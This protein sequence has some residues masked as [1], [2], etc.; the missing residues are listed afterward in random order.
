MIFYGTRETSDETNATT[1]GL[2]MP[3]PT[4][5]LQV[6]EDEYVKESQGQVCLTKREKSRRLSGTTS[7]SD[8]KVQVDGKEHEKERKEPKHNAKAPSRR[9]SGMNSKS[10]VR[11]E[12]DEN[13]TEQQEEERDSNQ[14]ETRILSGRKSNSCPGLQH[15]EDESARERQET[16]RVA[17]KVS[18]KIKRYAKNFDS[19]T[20]LDNSRIVPELRWS[21]LTFGDFLGKGSF[22]LV[23]EVRIKEKALGKLRDIKTRL[24]NS[25]SDINNELGG[26]SLSNNESKY[27]RFSTP[28]EGENSDAS[29]EIGD[30]FNQLDIDNA[31]YELYDA[32]EYDGRVPTIGTKYALKR[33]DLDHLKKEKHGFTDGA[34]DL[35][36]EAKLLRCI[37][38]E[39]IF[40]LHAVTEGSYSKAFRNEGY[41]LL[42]DRLY[43]TLE[44]KLHEWSNED[45]IVDQLTTPR[46]V[47]KR[48]AMDERLRSI[49]MPIV[50]AMKYLHKRK[51]V[52]RD[53]KPS[54]VGFT[55]TG[56]LKMFDFGLAKEIT[57]ENERHMTGRTGS[58]RY[59][60]PE[61]ALSADYNLSADVYSFAILLWEVC[62]L[63]RAFIGMTQEAHMDLIV[64]GNGRPM[65]DIFLF[66][67][68]ANLLRNSWHVNSTKR[69]SFIEINHLLV[70][71]FIEVSSYKEGASSQKIMGLKE[72]WLPIDNPLSR[73]VPT[74]PYF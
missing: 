21:D 57:K 35:V 30:V 66:G 11:L 2:P 19:S 39:D 14:K 20:S 50:N 59:M 3:Y 74:L 24:N 32:Q 15:D 70:S 9:I 34:I 53:L 12:V 63:Q 37:D 26:I 33:L 68:M 54:N 27:S 49:I 43:G 44:E 16:K 1:R 40:K 36:L 47:L 73:S 71:R 69:P 67:E 10:Y 72:K 18:S 4:G 48:H 17:K 64:R 29:L 60:A 58:L 31:A 7:K 55:H 62:S 5:K 23:Y 61:V 25:S 41:F 13:E 6:D 51:I 8:A 22:S 38:N 28:F 52:F 45:Q 65:L 46:H 56:E 42:L